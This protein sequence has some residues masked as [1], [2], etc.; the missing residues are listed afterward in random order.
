[1]KFLICPSLQSVCARIGYLHTGDAVIQGRLEAYSC[2]CATNSPCIWAR[3]ALPPPQKVTLR[4]WLLGKK[5]DKR[6]KQL[7]TKL[8]R[9]YSD[10][11]QATSLERAQSGQS[12]S[13]ERAYS[14]FTPILGSSA[15]GA[16]PDD[17]IL[18]ES[19]GGARCVPP[20]PP[21]FWG[22]WD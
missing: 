14:G 7:S 15:P 22:H 8:D 19:P 2:E 16:S 20:S 12:S 1:M 4:M 17:L 18:G 3:M 13:L 21:K 6:E 11:H 5:A 9:Q 10:G